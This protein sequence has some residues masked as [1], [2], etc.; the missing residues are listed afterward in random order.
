MGIYIALIKNDSDEKKLKLFRKQLKEE[1]AYLADITGNSDINDSWHQ[2]AS[3]AMRSSIF[4]IFNLTPQM[5]AVS[6]DI[7]S[8]FCRNVE[9]RQNSTLLFIFFSRSDAVFREFHVS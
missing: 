2:I 1:Q 4:M 9:R 8:A 5:A 7:I 6:L 3:S